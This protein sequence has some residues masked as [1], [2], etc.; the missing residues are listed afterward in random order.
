[1]STFFF[2]IM[3]QSILTNSENAIWIFFK[4]KFGQITS[5]K[6]DNV[7]NMITAADKDNN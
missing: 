2:L 1:M 3:A 7:L 4:D 5:D 6:I